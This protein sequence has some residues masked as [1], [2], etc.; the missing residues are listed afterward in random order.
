MNNF[1]RSVGRTRALVDAI[2][3]SVFG[4]LGLYIT[5]RMISQGAEVFGVILIA[6]L[7]AGLWW[8]AVRCFKRFQEVADVTE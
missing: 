4:L 1:V 2:L 8:R 3:A 5:V 6:G 7:T